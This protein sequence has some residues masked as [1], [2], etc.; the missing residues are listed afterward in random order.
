MF[1]LSKNPFAIFGR[2]GATGS[3]TPASDHPPDLRM[4]RENLVRGWSL[5]VLA[6]ALFLALTACV[7][8]GGQVGQVAPMGENAGPTPPPAATAQPTPSPTPTDPIAPDM[9]PAAPIVPAAEPFPAPAPTAAPV[10]PPPPTPPPTPL[11]EPT[12]K[13]VLLPEP[14]PVPQQTPTT[15]L[16]AAVADSQALVSDIGGGAML[17]ISPRS[18]LA[19]REISFSA[20]GLKPW[21]PVDVTFIDPQGLANNWITA[22]DVRVVQTNGDPVTTITLFADGDGRADW[23]RY[24]TQDVEGNWSVR[25]SLG[26]RIKAVGYNIG[27]LPL[28]TLETFT[29][30][31]P[32]SGYRGS[33]SDVF[34]SQLVPSALA[35]DLQPELDTASSLMEQRLGVSTEQ[36]PELYL[37]GNRDLLDMVS[38]ATG[39]ELGFE[40]GYY[41]NFGI[42]PGIYM[43]TDLLRTEVQRILVHEYVHLVFDGVAQGKAL[44]AWLSEGLAKYY[45]FDVGLAGDRPN[46]T[47]L[48]LLRSADAAARNGTLIPLPS[49]ESQHSWNSRTNADDITLQYAEAYMVIRYLTETF[50]APSPVNIVRQIGNGASLQSAVL[51]TTG[52]QYT[53]FQLLFGNWLL[54]WDD[55]NRSDSQE[56]LEVLDDMLATVDDVFE[57]RAV[58]LLSPFDRSQ[59]INVRTSIVGRAESVLERHVATAVPE[60]LQD[61][62]RESGEFFSVVLNWLKLELDHLETRLDARR[63][64][65]NF[66]IPEVDARDTMLRRK[67]D[68]AKFI[69]NLL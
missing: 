12:P 7:T 20:E 4:F 38:Q 49:L 23:V 62:H 47:K 55:S 15:P 3:N 34:Y 21:Q 43:R 25:I 28:T 37:L 22:D 44:P 31:T 32:L 18:P 16:A 35:V 10:R 63:L 59:S 60:S 29:L 17:R 64:E 5:L 69:L 57:Q 6:A 65:A 54:D 50:G 41:R 27:Q 30:G 26:D 14:V 40:D 51:T 24:G 58:D 11:P 1:T 46:A 67:L 52:L 33:E 45:E 61:L 66:L 39:V 48:R 36:V 56:Y 19:G 53:D 13:P 8:V 9:E 42:K 2:P 68:N